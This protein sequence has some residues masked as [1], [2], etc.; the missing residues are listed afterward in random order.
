MKNRHKL[1]I[2]KRKNF[3]PTLVITIL[4]WIV[5]GGL[6]YFVDP[7][8]FGAVPAFFILAFASFLFTFSL[9]FEGG[10]RGLIGAI[11][12]TLFLIL[13][14]LGVGNVLNLLLIVAIAICVELYLARS[15]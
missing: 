1:Q 2:L 7:G 12:L 6:I 11:A 4:L 9:I 14:F 5:L 15:Q 3:S 13:S 10:R 8:T